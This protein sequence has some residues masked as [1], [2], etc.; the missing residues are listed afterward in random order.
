VRQADI[1]IDAARVL[2]VLGSGCVRA[3][4]AR[5]LYLQVPGGLVVLV[6]RDAPRGPLHLRVAG[7]P[8]VGPGS[9]VRVG[10]GSLRIG[11]HC[12]GLDVPTWS[13]RLPPA[14]SLAQARGTARAW[15][16]D[17]GPALDI[18]SAA[19]GRLP[20][21][22]DAALR[23]GDLPAFAAAVGGRGPGLTPAG[24]DVLAGVLLVARAAR[25]RWP[26]SP[27]ARRRC[28]RVARTNDIA[29]AFLACAAAGRCI[30]PAHDLLAGLASADSRAVA[31][32]VQELGRFGSSSGAALTLGVR[33]ALLA[34][35]IP[36]GCTGR[37]RSRPTLASV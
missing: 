27:R 4:F 2:R 20:G 21:A 24:D 33:A 28:V 13:P 31:S 9:V 37:P 11:D 14:A 18:G 36:D 5:A 3:V 17:L 30:E 19:P 12:Y 25:S 32:A 10:P 26:T 16:P 23:R 8:A 22:A 7:L 6:T 15:L 29:S 35:P 1:G 34:L